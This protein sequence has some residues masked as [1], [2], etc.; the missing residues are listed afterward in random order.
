MAEIS[1]LQTYI[2]K[3]F[4][5]LYYFPSIID[6]NNYNNRVNAYSN[7]YSNIYEHISELTRNKTKDIYIST[8]LE[9]STINN[10]IKDLLSNYL[11]KIVSHIKSLE[12]YNYYYL[13]YCVISENFSNILAYFYKMLNSIANNYSAENFSYEEI[14]KTCWINYINENYHSWNNVYKCINI[15]II[16]SKTIIFNIS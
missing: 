1:K 13:K 6:E 11:L 4:I 14:S 8:Y 5:D 12:S 2:E 10:V 16:I 9:L 15:I 3:I 7:Y